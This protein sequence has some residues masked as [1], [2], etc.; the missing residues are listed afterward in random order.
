MKRH[1]EKADNLII[2]TFLG[3][4]MLFVLIG[5]PNLTPDKK[6][7]NT[8]VA[9]A[10][11]FLD[12]VVV[13]FADRQKALIPPQL[14][15]PII[16]CGGW[17]AFD[18]LP[19]FHFKMPN[20]KKMDEARK[21]GRGADGSLVIIEADTPRIDDFLISYTEPEPVNYDSI[22]ELIGYPQIALENGIEGTVVV[23]VHLD[24]TGK[25]IDWKTIKRAHP[26]LQTAVEE[27][28]GKLRFANISPK[29]PPNLYF[30]NVPFRF[31]LLE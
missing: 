9:G 28:V 3:I 19:E 8:G 18:L 20:P 26:V 4:G 21:K 24:T 23:R 12:T 27:N 15:E 11:H 1:T 22:Q 29:I 14:P 2:A 16:T 10:S 17:G 5:M 6:R 30:I 7:L 31:Q 13:R 25:V